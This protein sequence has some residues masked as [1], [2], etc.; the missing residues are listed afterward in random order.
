MHKK[1]SSNQ[2][3]CN[4]CE[5]M[6]QVLDQCT[7]ATHHIKNK[8]FPRLVFNFETADTLFAIHFFLEV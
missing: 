5:S 1:T 3:K 2:C 7:L 4:L 8:G 6:S